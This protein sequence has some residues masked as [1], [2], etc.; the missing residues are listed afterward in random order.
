MRAKLFAVAVAVCAAAL[1][2]AQGDVVAQL[3]STPAEANNTIFGAFSSGQVYMAGTKDVF[4]TANA[5]ARAA[6]ATAVVNVAR[7]YTTTADFARR[8]GV[9]REGQKPS[10]PQAGPTSMSEI[11]QQQKKAFEEAIKNMEEASKKMP[12][13]K[14]TFDEQIKSMR[15]QIAELSKSDPKANAEMDAIF[16]QGAEQQ[17]AQYKQQVAEWE[18]KFPVDPKPAVAARLREFL[19]ASA[20]VDYTAKLVKKDGKM[21]FENP[22]YERKDSN[23]K[24]MY[25]AGKPAVDA[26]RAVAEEWLKAL[27][28]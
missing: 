6:M 2:S 11:Q 12:Q 17:Q 14:A 7:A 3:G 15:A 13:M 9:Y 24:F 28:G 16:K 27:G 25:R 19:A 10:P 26:A 5:Q 4:L 21:K 20:T 18:K 1:V 8:W 23:W 22:A